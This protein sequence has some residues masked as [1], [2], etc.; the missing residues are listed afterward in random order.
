MCQLLLVRASQKQELLSLIVNQYEHMNYRLIMLPRVLIIWVN[1]ATPDSIWTWVIFFLLGQFHVFHIDC[2]LF[3]SWMMLD[4]SNATISNIR[5]NM[6]WSPKTSPFTVAGLVT[7]SSFE[8]PDPWTPASV[9]HT[10]RSHLM[11]GKARGK[12]QESP[13]GPGCVHTELL[14]HRLCEYN[15]HAQQA[16]HVLCMCQLQRIRCFGRF[17]KERTIKLFKRPNT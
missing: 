3:V 8:L 17:Q 14:W 12:L 9:V 15:L 13:T 6:T 5:S 16:L 4:T 11:V 2:G 7:G 1:V 10:V